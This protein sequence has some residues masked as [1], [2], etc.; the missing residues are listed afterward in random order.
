MRVSGTAAV[1][2]NYSAAAQSCGTARKRRLRAPARFAPILDSTR[3]T[4]YKAPRSS[5]SAAT[6]SRRPGSSVGRAR[7]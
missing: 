4:L 5:R 7:D 3:P 2:A 6:A 1:R